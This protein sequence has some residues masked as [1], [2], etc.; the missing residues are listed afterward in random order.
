MYDKVIISL[1]SKDAFYYYSIKKTL[2]F[3]ALHRHFF[4]VNEFYLI[5][6]YMYEVG[7]LVDNGSSS[8]SMKKLFK[9]IA[10]FSLSSGIVAHQINIFL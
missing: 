8:R 10:D 1:Q 7:I 4:D 5:C 2:N 3:K 9:P 6:K